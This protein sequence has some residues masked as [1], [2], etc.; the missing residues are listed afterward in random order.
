MRITTLALLALLPLTSSSQIITETISGS[1]SVVEKNDMMVTWWHEDDRIFFEMRA[2][3]DGWVAIGFN[4]TENVEGAY[5]LMGSVQYD[6]TEV[7]E[8]Y[9]ISPGN[10]KPITELGAEAQLD[11][12]FGTQ[13][14]SLTTIEF[15]VPVTAFSDY[16][17]DLSVGNTYVMILAYS[18]EDDFQHH[19]IMRTSVDVE[20]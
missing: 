3:T 6:V 7:V 2:P 1:I 8:H 14:D 9:T 10:Y 18:Q 15:S 11:D 12:V 16:Q 19:S 17:K 20:L 13:T 5:L 4:S